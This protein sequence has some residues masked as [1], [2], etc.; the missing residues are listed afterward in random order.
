[1]VQWYSYLLLLLSRNL[2]KLNFFDLVFLLSWGSISFSK[3]KSDP[4][5]QQIRHWKSDKIS[6]GNVDFPE[7]FLKSSLELAMVIKGLQ[8]EDFW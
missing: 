2:K 6:N 7:K 5:L 8:K 4:V 1:M 3:A